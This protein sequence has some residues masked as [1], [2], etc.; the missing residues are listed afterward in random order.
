S[1]AH[2]KY[3]VGMANDEPS[4]EQ[5]ISNLTAGLSGPDINPVALRM[6]FQ[7]ARAV[8]IP[9]IGIGGIQTAEEALEYIIAGAKGVQVGTANFYAPGTSLNVIAG[10]EE[11]CRRKQSH[12]HEL[13]G[14]LRVPEA[15]GANTWG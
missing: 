3:I 12:L 1:P 6:V 8:K 13:V 14:S 4:R 2:V 10:I 11:Y 9:V 15:L 5:R 7:A